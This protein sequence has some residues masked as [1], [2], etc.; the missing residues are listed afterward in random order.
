MRLSL[1]SFLLLPLIEIAGF[2]IVGGT[3]GVLPTLGLTMLTTATGIYL[4]RRQGI[5]ILQRLNDGIREE[6]E[7]ARDV[8]DGAMVI[9]GAILLMIPGFVTDLLGL[10]LFIP[11]VR[12]VVWS[13]LRSRI[14]V[15]RSAG[16]YYTGPRSQRG[17][18]KPGE[19]CGHV[20]DL[21]ADEFERDP[22]HPSS[23]WRKV[24]PPKGS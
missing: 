15:A 4:L 8:A 10:L 23:R 22:E 11:S 5:G 12:S 14:T 9:M 20:V 16:F 17:E 18:N 6:T 21:G 7:A 3:I 19:T 2:V 24:E 1:L 13:F